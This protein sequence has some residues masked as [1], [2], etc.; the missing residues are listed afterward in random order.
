ML[1]S[2]VPVPVSS[3]LSIAFLALSTSLSFCLEALQFDPRLLL[4]RRSKTSIPRTQHH[5]SAQVAPTVARKPCRNRE[6][7]GVRREILE[8]LT[9]RCWAD[10]PVLRACLRGGPSVAGVGR[11]TTH[12][13]GCGEAGCAGT[14]WAER[15]VLET[16]VGV[17]RWFRGGGCVVGRWFGWVR[18]RGAVVGRCGL[19]RRLLE[20]TRRESTRRN[21]NTG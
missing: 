7:R 10:V 20:Q 5:N 19:S 1:L 14:G 17:P 9:P 21:I 16:W 6:P 3:I 15:T 11:A 2:A 12:R 18:L 4:S 8:M 13:L